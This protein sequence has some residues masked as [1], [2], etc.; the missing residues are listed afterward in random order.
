ML[1]K[2]I[3]SSLRV[4][5]QAKINNVSQRRGEGICSKGEYCWELTV[6]VQGEWECIIAFCLSLNCLM[7]YISP[8][9]VQYLTNHSAVL[10]SAGN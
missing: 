5:K 4:F 6:L 7:C 8:T 9:V 2:S 1:T 3:P 10:W